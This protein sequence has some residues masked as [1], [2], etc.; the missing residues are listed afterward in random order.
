MFS[1]KINNQVLQAKENETILQCAMRN[2]MY[3]PHLCYHPKTGICGNCRVCLVEVANRL[4]PACSTPVSPNMEVRTKSKMV[5]HTVT[6][7]LKLILESG[8]HS[9][10]NCPANLHCALQ[11]AVFYSEMDD[12]VIGERLNKPDTSSEFIV[13]DIDKCIS[14]GNCVSGC[15]NTVVN[16]VIN[17]AD[18][19]GNTRITIDYNKKLGESSC[20]QCG[21]CSQL[22]PVGAIYDKNSKRAYRDREID[23]IRSICTY[24]GVGCNIEI[25]TL[26]KTGEIIRIRGVEDSEVNN[27]MLCSKGRFGFRF[28]HSDRRL[29]TP[30]IKQNG[31]HVP[32]DWNT[33]IEIIA[34]KFQKIINEN[35]SNA[36]GGFSSAK[37]SNEDNYLFQ[38]FFRTCIGNNN[39]DHCARLCHASTVAGLAESLGSGAMTNN[40][41][42]IHKADA[43]LVIGSDT[44]AAHPI[45]GNKIKQ[46]VKFHNTKLIVIDPKKIEL[47]KFASIYAS[48]KPGSDT[49]L[50]NSI[51]HVIIKK[52]LFDPEYIKSRTDLDSWTLFKNEMLMTKYAP[53]TIEEIAG[54]KASTLY[55]I[56]ELFGK[57]KT[58]AVYFAM[59]ITQHTSGYQNVLA[60]ANLQ[61]MCGNIGI[62]G[63]GVNPLR[64]QSNVQ[65]ACDVGCLPDTLPGYAKVSNP[66]AIER[67]AD[68]W[69]SDISNKS[70]LTIT[71]MLDS[72]IS[73]DIKAIYVMGE[74]P[75]LSDPDQTHT[76]KAL[77]NLDLLIVQDIFMTETA[78]MADIVLPA[79]CFSEKTGHFTNTERRVQKLRKATDAPGLVENDWKI[80]TDLAN[81][82]G[83]NWEYSNSEDITREINETIPFYRG[84]TS[85][86]T[87]EDGIQWPC[88]DIEHPGTSIL[89]ENSFPIGLPKFKIVDYVPPYEICS[90]E[91]PLILTTGRLAHQFHTGTM[92]RKSEE[93]DRLSPPTIKI[94][95]FDAAQ[96]SIDNG[97]FVSVSS[98]RGEI[99]IAAEVT[100]R[101]KKGVVFISFHFHESPANRLTHKE[102]DPVAKIPEYKVTAVQVKKLIAN[103]Y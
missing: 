82:M 25:H 26:K 93:F 56:G 10:L 76:I 57:A 84:I 11:D 28:V 90:R 33:V 81:A 78:E 51:I 35:G 61:L 79:A 80:V 2:N 64:G 27:G 60:L 22:C 12:Y 47:A 97:E 18:R 39:V 98:A 62:P 83:Y 3:I 99:T 55:E 14:C 31:K 13:K 74:N 30:L 94:S 20:V 77:K 66:E 103:N 92:I 102:I 19:G 1:I 32:T 37:C 34:D 71:E 44:T 100:D 65:G 70:G 38:K 8:N 5:R 96:R 9:C 4:V 91:Y 21:E 48:Q 63:A 87:E 52:N 40:L 49:A 85:D 41:Q 54:I 73:G 67:F 36:I 6:M 17:F 50:I 29:T 72:A 23:K 88:P 95:P 89:H 69:K 42:D 16:E 58:A 15:N 43:I 24:C 75:V 7:I 101:I 46:A 86:R 45:I 53:E 68:Y 59:G